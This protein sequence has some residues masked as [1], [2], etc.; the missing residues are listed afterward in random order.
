ME[1][2]LISSQVKGLYSPFYK[3]ALLVK[4]VK[5]KIKLIQ[6]LEDINEFLGFT[7][8]HFA[9]YDQ[10]FLMNVSLLRDLIIICDS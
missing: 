1:Q 8:L 7:C 2:V 10:K 6:T 4:D 9:H 5:L 3:T